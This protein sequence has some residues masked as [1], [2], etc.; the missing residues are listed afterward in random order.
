MLGPGCDLTPVLEK[1][2]HEETPESLQ[3]AAAAAAAAA[4]GPGSSLRGY[5]AETQRAPVRR[6]RLLQPA[7]APL[8]RG[9][10]QDLRRQRVSHPRSPELG[11]FTPCCVRADGSR[12]GR[13]AVS[14]RDT[15]TRPSGQRAPSAGVLL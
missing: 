12:A 2:S 13:A 3:T 4:S 9:V 1:R 8:Q 6:Q 7:D 15:M 14:R 11:W 10:S 5:R